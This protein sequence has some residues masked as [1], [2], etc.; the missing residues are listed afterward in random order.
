MNCCQAPHLNMHVS[1]FQRWNRVAVRTYPPDNAWLLTQF[2]GFGLKGLA[3]M[4]T[5]Q[6]TRAMLAQN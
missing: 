4:N 6:A 2:A 3:V 1:G 5:R